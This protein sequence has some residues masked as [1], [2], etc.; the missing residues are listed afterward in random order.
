MKIHSTCVNESEE[1]ERDVTSEFD[2]LES[3]RR[4]AGKE[5]EENLVH[6]EPEN[7]NLLEL[8]PY[9]T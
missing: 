1:V 6:I 4:D 3:Q 7:E 5:L 9:S 2:L 8:L